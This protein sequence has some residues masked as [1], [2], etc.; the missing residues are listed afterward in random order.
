MFGQQINCFDFFSDMRSLWSTKSGGKTFTVLVNFSPPPLVS[1]DFL[2]HMIRDS[3]MKTLGVKN[4]GHMNLM[5]GTKVDKD[6][7]TQAKRW[8]RC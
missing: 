4:I 7:K 5:G 1:Q 8:W 3:C 2:G 6:G